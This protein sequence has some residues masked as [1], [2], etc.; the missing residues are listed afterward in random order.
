MVTVS[1][2]S[3]T[4]FKKDG[5]AVT[6]EVI[7][8]IAEHA[9]GSMGTARIVEGNFQIFRK[10]D[11]INADAVLQKLNKELLGSTLII[12]ADKRKPVDDELQ[13]LVLLA[14]EDDELA[15]AFYDGEVDMEK[16]QLIFDETLGKCAGDVQAAVKLLDGPALRSRIA[17]ECWKE[18][19]HIVLYIVDGT[20]MHF[21]NNQNYREFEWG[22]ATNTFEPAPAPTQSVPKVSALDRMKAKQKAGGGDMDMTQPAKPAPAVPG[23]GPQP[24]TALPPDAGK[25]PMVEVGPPPSGLNNKGKRSWWQRKVGFIPAHYKDAKISVSKSQLKELTPDHPI[26]VAAKATEAAVVTEA[27][28]V[29]D[30]KH[31]IAITAE[32]GKGKVKMRNAVDAQKFHDTYPSWSTQFQKDIPV[33]DVFGWDFE[34]K[35]GLCVKWPLAT[36]VLLEEV[37]TLYQEALTDLD[38]ATSSPRQPEPQPKP[39]EPAKPMTALE[40]MKARQSK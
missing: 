38:A 22:W 26:P 29:L 27:H 3:S 31:I 2:E 17:K 12:H 30:P 15:I 6:K 4:F 19:G 7:A 34:T 1:N 32:F 16:F 21:R 24:D 18:R 39:A 10:A 25:E 13:P 20:L 37:V 23:T 5:K 14:D 8:Q 40:R 11:A 28:T 9:D 35:R 33:E 36:A